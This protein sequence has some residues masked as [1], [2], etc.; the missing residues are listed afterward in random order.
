MARGHEQT[1]AAA[2][3]GLEDQR[4][5][6]NGLLRWAAR[7]PAQADGRRAGPAPRPPSLGCP[8][9]SWPL[10]V[11]HPPR[12]IVT[13][14]IIGQRLSSPIAVAGIADVYEST[15]S[16]RLL[17]AAGAEIARTYT[18]AHCLPQYAFQFSPR[19]DGNST[20]SV[21][22]RLGTDQPGILQVFE[23]SAHGSQSLT[24]NIAVALAASGS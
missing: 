2:R 18:T 14:P 16:L 4:P 12:I 10:P 11:P 15:V 7:R 5:S 9:R 17:D 19:G 8:T 13:G 22:Y 24:V 21:S 6:K 3:A 1:V 20:T 23:D